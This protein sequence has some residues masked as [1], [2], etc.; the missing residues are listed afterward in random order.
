MVPAQPPLPTAWNFPFHPSIGS[1]TSISMFES[2]EGLRTAATRQN[3]GRLVNVWPAPGP[4]GAPVVGG[5]NPPAATVCANVIVVPGSANE[6]NCS[7]MPAAASLPGAVGCGRTA[8][9]SIA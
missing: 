2:E 7:H 6:L 9:S 5:A 8:A 4:P 1:Q 3:D